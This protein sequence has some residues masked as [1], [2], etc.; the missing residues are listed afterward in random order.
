MTLNITNETQFEARFREQM[1]SLSSPFDR[2]IMQRNTQLILGNMRL[3]SGIIIKFDARELVAKNANIL[4]MA[5]TNDTA[6]RILLAARG[7]KKYFFW[8]NTTIYDMTVSTLQ[9]NR[10]VLGP[11]GQAWLMREI[12]RFQRFL[13]GPE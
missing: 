11:K 7:M 5:L 2:G 9:E 4:A 3:I 6:K 13:C 1:A 12:Q 10:I 8:D